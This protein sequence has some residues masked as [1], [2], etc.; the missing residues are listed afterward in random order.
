VVAQFLTHAQ[1]VKEEIED[2]LDHRVPLDL[3]DLLEDQLDTPVF[4][5]LLVSLDT[6]DQGGLPGN[7]AFLGKLQILVRLDL[8]DIQVPQVIQE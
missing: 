1:G 2:F 4:A 7:K 5:G 3:E 8:L 6:L